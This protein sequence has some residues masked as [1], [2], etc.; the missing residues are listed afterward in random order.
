MTGPI[1]RKNDSASRRQA[2]RFVTLPLDERIAIREAEIAAK[3]KARADAA[4]G[5]EIEETPLSATERQARI[6]GRGAAIDEPR[7]RGRNSFRA[8]G[9]TTTPD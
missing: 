4:N 1:E 6:I 8:S 5:E 9:S 2:A 3:K 7:R